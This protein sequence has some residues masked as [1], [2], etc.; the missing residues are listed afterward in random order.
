M[1]NIDMVQRQPQA[2][3]IAPTRLKLDLGN[4]LEIDD[5]LFNFVIID[6]IDHVRVE[7]SP[8]NKLLD[9]IPLDGCQWCTQKPFREILLGVFDKAETTGEKLTTF[10][11]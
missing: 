1:S 9:V 4:M 2:L 8:A 7:E 10:F 3:D 11:L 5:A 6:R